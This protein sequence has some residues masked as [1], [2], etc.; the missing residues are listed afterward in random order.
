MKVSFGSV[1]DFFIELQKKN[2]LS[3][4][5][6]TST[7]DPLDNHAALQPVTLNIDDELKNVDKMLVQCF[8]VGLLHTQ[9]SRR[10]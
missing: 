10:S 6:Y 8:K 3:S 5:V 4:I 7:G 9:T 2:V 1:D